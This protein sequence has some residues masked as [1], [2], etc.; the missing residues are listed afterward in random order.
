MN[1]TGSSN[2]MVKD[3]A[4]RI[5]ERSVEK[6]KL[7]YT[8]MIS[9]A[10]S[11]TYLTSVMQVPTVMTIPFPSR[12]ALDTFK[13]VCS[14]TCGDNEEEGASGCGRQ[15]SEDWWKRSPHQRAHASASEVLWQSYPLQR[16]GSGCQISLD[17][18]IF[19]DS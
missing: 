8:S 11:S 15:E 6:Y 3:G 17:Y 10:D 7:R 9:D 1:Y 18:L 16:G 5:C 2:A 4:V 14:S 13:N 19:Q 12:S